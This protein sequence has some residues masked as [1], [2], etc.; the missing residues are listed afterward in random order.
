MRTSPRRGH[1]PTQYSRPRAEAARMH[2]PRCSGAP[3]GAAN[4]RRNAPS[5]WLRKDPVTA[6][7]HGR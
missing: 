5:T 4:D 6:T 1:R 2:S 7:R 3:A